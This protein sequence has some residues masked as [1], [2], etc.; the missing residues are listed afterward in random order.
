MRLINRLLA[1][2]LALALAAA[3][4]LAAAEVF[5]ARTSWTPANPPLVVPYDRWLATLR[6]HHWNQTPVLLISIG[7]IV[8]GLLFIVAGLG[9]RER[10]IRLVSD[11]ADV[12]ASTSARSLRRVLRRDAATVD[13]VAR[14][15]TRARAG[16]A[17][18]RVDVRLGEPSEV[19]A[20]IRD[21]VTARI[22]GL[23]L[24]RQPA[25]SVRADDARRYR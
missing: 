20:E 12:A 23:G 3:G 22:G 25:L 19:E 16:R 17:R 18:V 4:G 14:A 7:A 8:L 11:S 2:V 24:A 15:R 10:R 6:D 9:G 13:G 5:V 21:V 1:A